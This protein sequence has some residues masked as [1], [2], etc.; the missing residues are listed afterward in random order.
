MSDTSKMLIDAATRLFVDL[1]TRETVE[2]AERGDWPQTLWRAIEDAGLTLAATSEARGGPG[3]D[4]ANVFALLKAAGGFAVPVPLAETLLAEQALAAA[5]LSPLSGPITIGPVLESERVV[6]LRKDGHWKASGVLHRIPWARHAVAVVVTAEY[7]GRPATAIIR[8]PVVI[9]QDVNLAN[10]SR[11]TVDCSV[12]TIDDGDVALDCGF[13]SGQLRARGALSRAAGIA[14]ALEHILAGTI[15]YAKDRVQF[16]KPISKFQA[17]QQQAA[18]LAGEVAAACAAVQ[19]AVDAL[20]QGDAHFQIAAAKARASEA[21]GIAAAI[22][23]QVHG[24]IGFTHE[25]TLHW[26]TRRAWSWRDEFGDEGEW[27]RWIGLAVA[28]LGGADLW[29]YLTAPDAA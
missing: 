1:C 16:G 13:N 21:A 27:S 10:E 23:H 14:G 22:A 7:D 19:A 12:A 26:S 18:V 25:H 8:S 11:D 17:I 2:A 6:L 5:G 24:A 9:A 4:L 20:E 3:A 15:A 29:H 28:R